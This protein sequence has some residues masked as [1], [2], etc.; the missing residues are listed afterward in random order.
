MKH[1]LTALLVLVAPVSAFILGAGTVAAG[2]GESRDG[3]PP[4]VPVT[5]P[6]SIPNELCLACHGEEG[7]T[8][9]LGTGW[10]QVVD[11]IDAAAFHDSAHSEVA[12]ISC[13]EAQQT[14]PHDDFVAPSGGREGDLIDSGELCASCH[15]DEH[16]AYFET[17]HGTVTNLGDSRAPMCVDCHGAHN[18]QRIDGWSHEDRGEMCAKCHHGADA[19]F[20]QS[21]MGHTEASPSWFPT[22]YFAGRFLIILTAAVLAIGVLHTELDVLRWGIARARSFSRFGRGR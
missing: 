11:V 3:G 20:A 19:A 8:V 7:I 16:E 1:R 22:S 17:A 13:H 15:M 14:L 18:V 2:G 12:C 10:V 5:E 21:A 4:E 6:G 9:D